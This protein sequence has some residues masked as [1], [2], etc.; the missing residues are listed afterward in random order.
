MIPLSREQKLKH[1]TDGIVYLFLPP[2]GDLEIDLIS[3]V[4]QDDF[5]ILPAQYEKAKEELTKKFNG[6]R[7]PKK[8]KW[9]ELIKQRIMESHTEQDMIKLR[10]KEMGELLDKVL[11]G[12]EGEKAIPFPEGNP[13]QTL[14]FVL[15]SKLYNWYQGQWLLEEGE[16]KN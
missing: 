15:K 3:M 16:L 4:K 13:S 12:W 10:S 5:E 1:E 6:K 7:K 8:E 11:V 14:P 9:E 2:V